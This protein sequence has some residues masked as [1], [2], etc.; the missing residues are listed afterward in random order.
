MLRVPLRR[1]RGGT[2]GT[3]SGTCPAAALAG[4]VSGWDTDRTCPISLRPCSALYRARA[5]PASAASRYHQDCMPAISG[6]IAP[7]PASRAASAA[8]L[9]SSRAS[10]ACCAQITLTRADLVKYAS[11]SGDFNPMYH[12]E[13]L[14]QAAGMPPVFGHGM[15]SRGFLCTALAG[16]AGPGHVT[17]VGLRFSKQTWPGGMDWAKRR[18]RRPSCRAAVLRGRGGLRGSAGARISYPRRLGPRPEAT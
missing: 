10:M 8:F 15:F 18:G 11:A 2:G 1:V 4:V 3:A 14:V 7:H 9:R 13:P 6:S 5:I 16:W 12:D 17:R